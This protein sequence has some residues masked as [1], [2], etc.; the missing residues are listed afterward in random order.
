MV[1]AINVDMYL[2]TTKRKNRDGSV[3]TYYQLAHNERHPET[4]VSTPRVIHSFGRADLVD[5]QELVRLCHSIA[6]A[7]GLVIQ[8]PV[9]EADK[10][11]PFDKG[12]PQ[13][14]TLVGTVELGTV[15][16]IEALWLR[17]GIGQ[18]FK[19]MAKSKGYKERYERA[20][21]AMTANR[22]CDPQSK[23]GVWDR[24]L[25]QVFLPSCK[26][27]KLADRHEAMDVFHK[28]CSEI[29][30]RIF[31]ATADLFNLDVDVVFYDTTTASFT[32]D[33][34]DVDDDETPQAGLR[35]FGHPKEGGWKVQVVVALTV[36][37][38]GF[39]VRSWVFPGNTT[40]VTTVE[41]VKA[42][43]KGWKLGRALFVADAGMNS[44]DM[45]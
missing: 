27:L 37:R 17:L 42:D 25:S 40:D 21:L 31:F 4:K 19:E 12:L 3:V 1:H 38:E 6:K 9:V 26:D 30:Q 2:R 35:K 11:S 10:E 7:C 5:R 18:V 39:P 29:E 24:W 32:L 14:I 33:E 44:A 34:A 28:H 43:L 8:D 20:L 16:V 23:L 13:D 41:Q 22:L 36:T 45:R 15:V